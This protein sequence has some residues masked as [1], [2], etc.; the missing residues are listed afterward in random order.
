MARS[1]ATA[2]QAWAREGTDLGHTALLSPGYVL[3]IGW[4]ESRQPL[5]PCSWD[6]SRSVL[7]EGFWVVPVASA[8]TPNRPFP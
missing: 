7:E 5:T 8:L 4:E 3:E 1:Q 6:S 2:F